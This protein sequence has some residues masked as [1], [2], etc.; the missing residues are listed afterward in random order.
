MSMTKSARRR[1]GLVVALAGSLLA[2]PLVTMP[3]AADDA[4]VDGA[5]LIST[6]DTT[7]R[8]LDDNTE[9]QGGNPDVL[10]WT[11]PTFDDAAWKSA[12]GS[13]GS[14]R[15]GAG[16]LEG[17]F[18][19]NTLTNHY[20]NGSANPTIPAY[21]FRHSFEL[22]AT[23]LDRI[24]DLK[25]RVIAD[26]AVRVYVNGSLVDNHRDER[27]TDSTKN[28]QYAGTS[29]SQPFTRDFSFGPETLRVGT[30]TVSVLL[31][32]DRNSSSDE[33]FDFVSLV[34][35]LAA[36][37][38][39]PTPGEQQVEVTVPERTTGPGEF[40]WTIDGSNDLVDLGTAALQGD[41]FVAAGAINP[42]RV[43]DSR[44]G[45]PAWTVSGQVG[46]FAA[47]ADSFD[48]KHLGWTPAVTEN[49]GGAFAGDRVLSGLTSGNG[50]KD[51][52]VL[53]HAPAGHVAGSSLLG[54][55]LELALPVDV[56]DG[57]YRGTL[58]LTALG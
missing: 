52:S 47:G 46:D 4:P 2:A 31:Y 45:A 54:A 50:L 41:R 49:E 53:G 30:N 43:T 15:G 13:F 35:V 5:P 11:A 14:L 26:D 10:A 27:A 20:V 21:F 19:P 33:Y 34:P 1:F 12:K 56:A 7:W 8:Y 9:P 6:A 39:Q 55:L 58:T 25:G 17:G 44:I 42:V 3:A 48:G 29:A 32:Q 40:V 37:P 16:P 36:Q 23:T 18:V 38:Q 28:L 24:E 51:A 22:D 57:T